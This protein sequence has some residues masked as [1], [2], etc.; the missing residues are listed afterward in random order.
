MKWA[1]LDQHLLEAYLLK[2]GKNIVK[3]EALKGSTKV[4]ILKN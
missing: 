3:I 1:H 2:V 4:Y